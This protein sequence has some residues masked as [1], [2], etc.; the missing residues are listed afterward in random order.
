MT[1]YVAYM[2]HSIANPSRV[3]KRLSSIGSGSYSRANLTKPQELR[4]M[5][6]HICGSIMQAATRSNA[7]IR[8]TV[9]LTNEKVMCYKAYML[10]NTA[11]SI[12]LLLMD[13]RESIGHTAATRGGRTAATSAHSCPLDRLIARLGSIPLPSLASRTLG[14]LVKEDAAYLELAR[15]RRLG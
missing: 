13:P 5:L 6:P 8:C 10:Y 14:S 1:C 15:N 3:V 11:P 7:L 12:R 9:G 2:L 4:I